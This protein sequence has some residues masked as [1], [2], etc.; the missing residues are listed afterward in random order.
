MRLG[1][2][3]PAGPPKGQS[4]DAR[5]WARTAAELEGLGYDSIWAF[6][7]VGRGFMLPDP[8]TALTIVAT[9]TD[10]VELGTGVL[11]LPWRALADVAYRAFTLQL[12]SSGRFLLGIGPGSTEKDFQAM[13]AGTGASFAG[14]F[15]AF[16]QQSAE[17]VRIL[18]TGTV[19]D[20]D[21]TP[22][23]QT[24]GGPP[25]MVG[26]WR[27]PWV[28]RAA[29]EFDGWIASAGYNDDATLAEALD[30]F[31][32]AG[33]KRAVVTNVQVGPDPEP[34]LDRLRGLAAMGFDDGVAF[35]LAYTPERA[36]LIRAAIT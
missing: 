12:I 22:W 35:D 15:R 28:S 26:A 17:L 9:S 2:V 18:R 36:A 14:R 20:I 19:N 34:G 24:V 1:A 25:V 23:P 7:G 6:D 27:G 30:R 32:Q 31:R 29:T 21:L 10:R 33:G 5:F 8:L 16:E 11:Q 4:I 3:L 13:G